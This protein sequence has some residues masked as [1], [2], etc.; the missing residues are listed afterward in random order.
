MGSVVSPDPARCAV[1]AVPQDSAKV[2]I[3]QLR[4][5]ALTATAADE[6]LQLYLRF[7]NSKN[8]DLGCALL[9]Y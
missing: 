7:I 4:S 9:S 3:G 6:P 8:C 2:W 5:G 1:C